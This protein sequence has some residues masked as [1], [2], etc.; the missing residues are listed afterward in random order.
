MSTE[1]PDGSVTAVDIHDCAKGV[2][3]ST[4]FRRSDDRSCKDLYVLFSGARSGK[5]VSTTRYANRFSWKFCGAN[6]VSI[7]DPIFF[8]NPHAILAGI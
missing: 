8:T 4:F 5:N 2:V 7:I 6:V 1:Y 3:A